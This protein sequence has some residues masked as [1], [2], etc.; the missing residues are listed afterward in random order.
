MY[1]YIRH[2]LVQLVTPGVFSLSCNLN[3]SIILFHSLRLWEI[4]ISSAL[5]L[6]NTKYLPLNYIQNACNI[7][8]KHTKFLFILKTLKYC[9]IA[10]HNQQY[11]ENFLRA[12]FAR[13]LQIQ[14]TK[15]AYNSRQIEDT[16]LPHLAFNV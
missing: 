13:H 4:N 11:V 8:A 10:V 7:L 2:D 6:R 5:Y 16:T 3:G 14:R 9:T 12:N 15:R 1:N